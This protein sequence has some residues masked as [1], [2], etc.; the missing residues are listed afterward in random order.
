MGRFG[1][2][3]V[4][5]IA[6]R[7]LEAKGHTARPTAD[8]ARQ[9]HEQRMLRVHHNALFGKLPLQTAARHRVAEEQGL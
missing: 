7:Q 2:N 9:I 8:A 1:E 3:A 5:V 6:E 4:N